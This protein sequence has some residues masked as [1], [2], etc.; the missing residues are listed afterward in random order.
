MKTM[1]KG[2]NHVA[3][4]AR[5]FRNGYVYTVDSR[6]TV[7]E[8]IAVGKDGN[9]LFVGSNVAVEAFCTEGTVVTDLTGKFVLPGFSD[10]HTHVSE[11]AAKFTSIYL[12]EVKTVAEYL[13]IIRAFAMDKANRKANFVTG[14]NWEQ[15]VFQDYNLHT[16]G[17]SPDQQLGPSR[18]LLDEALRG[19][20]LE[21][22]PVKIYSNDLHCVWYNSAA[23]ELARGKGFDV[24]GSITENRGSDIIT[25]IPAA[26]TGIYHGVDFAAYQGQPWGVFREQAACQFIDAYLPQV[27][28]ETKRRQAE[29]GMQ[30]FLREMHSYGVTLLQDVLL[31]PLAQ[32]AHVDYM[33]KAL[34]TSSSHMLW[35]VSLFGDVH[36]PEK[37]VR[38]FR[39]VQRKYSGTEEFQFFSVKVF[40]DGIQKGMYVMEPY[41]DDP[42]NPS[43]IGSLYNDIPLE[44]LK[45]F[46]SVMHREN[47]PI[48]IHAM[49]DRA[50]K[51][52]LDV[53]EEAW[54]KYGEKD[55]RHTITHLL[56]VR[57]EDIRRMAK[58][59]VIASVNSY[60]N[61]KEP[62]YYEEIFV[63]VLGRKRA[64]T[65]FPASSFF[66]ENILTCMASDGVISEK[67]S[68]LWGIE[69]AVTRNS[70][71]GTTSERL[72]NPTERISRQQAIEMCTLSG[73][74]A[75]GLD[76]ITGSLEV[77]KR[78]D[79]VILDK[80]LF[81]IA[82]SEIHAVEVLE[83]ISKGKTLYTLPSWQTYK[84]QAARDMNFY[85]PERRLIR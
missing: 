17:I 16:Y 31:T 28:E 85:Q 43:N 15:A 56:L 61:Y 40:A 42:R 35:R 5:V 23:I 72:H 9:I 45:R 50:V 25:R 53:L 24:D 18:F 26:F 6:Q 34:K 68:P 62:F 30:G 84:E 58:L 29:I 46:L 69:I 52:C 54:A 63:P 76:A 2:G 77:G 21:H 79:L 12:G 66:R 13:Q 44:K 64:A 80:N 81:T 37:T 47:I 48:H 75:L 51:E 59:K 32:N 65:S 71:G 55:L 19:T 27:D 10:N 3:V 38:E 8:A 67:P 22:V 1:Q 74:K 7:A 14:S 49:G 82:A 73:A 20:F 41:A 60:W 83:T 11:S 4:A 33:Y 39:E 57:P 70:L 36:D 78:A